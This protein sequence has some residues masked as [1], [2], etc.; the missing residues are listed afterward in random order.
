MAKIYQKIPG[1]IIGQFSKMK[2]ING[3]NFKIFREYFLAKYN[4]GF[5]VPADTF[6][7]VKGNFPIGF[8]IWDTSVKNKIDII[9]TDVYGK[10]GNYLSEK[11]FYGNL[12]KGINQ[13]INKFQDNINIQIGFL[14]CSTPDF[15]NKNYVFIDNLE[16]EKNDHRFHL[17][18]TK[19]NLLIGSIYFAVRHCI[20]ATWLNDRDQFLHPNDG[21]KKDEIFQS[22]CLI[23][24][25]CP[26]K[27]F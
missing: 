26:I 24:H 15:Q 25:C 6:D 23:Y 8:T 17:Y 7:N 4:A 20:E 16:N 12:P 1:C 2:F 22:D 14:D 13:W 18:F 27:V 5:I 21:W 19:N 9:K 3:S 10:N 11:G